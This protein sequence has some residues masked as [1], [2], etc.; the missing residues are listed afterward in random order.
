MRHEHPL[1]TAGGKE[2]PNIVFYADIT[3]QNSERKDIWYDNMLDINISKPIP[4]ADPGFQIRGGVHFKKL[5]RAEGEAKM[6]GVF[7][8]KNHHFRQKKIISF[9]ILGGSAPCSPPWVRPWFRSCGLQNH[10]P[11]PSTRP[12]M[13]NLKTIVDNYNVFQVHYIV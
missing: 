8:V 9:P 13:K 7:R 4:G 1:L 2:E 10:P 11:T 6:F 12:S 5:R 3:T